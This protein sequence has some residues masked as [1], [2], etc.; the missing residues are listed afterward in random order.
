MD[1]FLQFRMPR[2]NPIPLMA[3][4]HAKKSRVM[5]SNR[6][7]HFKK[8]LLTELRRHAQQINS[9][10]ARALD[11]ANDEAKESSDLALRDVIQELA[12]KLSEHE[13]RIVADIDQA[14]RRMEEG[15][16]GIC[17]RCGHPIDERR[18]EAMPTARLDA[19]CQ[20]AIE[21]ADGAPA[22]PSL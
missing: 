11:I 9:E 17:V 14:L 15:S 16:Y 1:R 10:Q 6:Q 8:L 20:T 19:E 21:N 3:K 18:L 12:L 2:Y 13:S 4:K 7:K 22:R 5:N